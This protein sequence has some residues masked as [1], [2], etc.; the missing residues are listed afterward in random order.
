M[1]GLCFIF[2]YSLHQIFK[3]GLCKVTS[4]TQSTQALSKWFL[5]ISFAFFSRSIIYLNYILLLF[6]IGS[7]IGELKKSIANLIF[8]GFDLIQINFI[9]FWNL[10]TWIWQWKITLY[11][12]GV[13]KPCKPLTSPACFT[14]I[15]LVNC[16]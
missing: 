11:T 1:T 13:I 10:I 12:M 16:G 15:I 9:L 2:C 3:K 8:K 5:L 14:I 6:S 4:T 7:R